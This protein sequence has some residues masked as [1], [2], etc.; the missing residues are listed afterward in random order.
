MLRSTAWRWDLQR[1]VVVR[2]NYMNVESFLNTYNDVLVTE[3]R[4]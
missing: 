4:T 3:I 1:I 2:D